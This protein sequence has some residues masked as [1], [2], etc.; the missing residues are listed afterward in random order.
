MLKFQRVK[1]ILDDQYPIIPVMTWLPG[2]S[3]SSDLKGRLLAQKL[4]CRF[5]IVGVGCVTVYDMGMGQ[6]PVAL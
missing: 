3:R 2:I 1:N 5:N 4:A 6:N